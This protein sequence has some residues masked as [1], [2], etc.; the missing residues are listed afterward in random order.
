ME[1]IFLRHVSISPTFARV[2]PF[3]AQEDGVGSEVGLSSAKK[4]LQERIGSLSRKLQLGYATEYA[5]PYLR[6]D[7]R[8]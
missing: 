1:V 4:E 2:S 8:R 6:R 5:A 7:I 3:F